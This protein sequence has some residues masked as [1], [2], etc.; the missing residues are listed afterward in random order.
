M[1]FKPV[2]S[3]VK[4]PQL[5]EEMLSFWQE[6][7]V[8]E[9][10]LGQRQGNE[11][12]VFYDGPPFATGLPHYGHLLAGTI[13]DVI[14]RFQ[15]M[16][17]K[18]V[19]R[20]F[21]WDCHGL[22]IESLIQ[23]ELKLSGVSEIQEFGIDKFNEACRDSVLTYTNEW[24]QTVGR[25]GR[26]VDFKNGYK[27][28]D[29]D[30]MESVWWV[31][32]RC[33]DLGLIYQGYR[34]QPYSPALATPLS[35]FETNQ[36]YKDRQDPSLT[37]LFPFHNEEKT[38][39]IVWTTTPWTLPSNMAVAVGADIDYV[40]V[41]HEDWKLWVAAARKDAYFGEE[42]AVIATAKGS[43]LA[44]T[45]YIS[46]FDYI[47]ERK[48]KLYQIQLADF[49]ST[50]DGTGA[51]HIAPSFGEDDFI[52]GQALGLPLFDP[53]DT[54]GKFTNLVPEWQ[55]QGAK[56][57]DKSIIQHLKQKGRIFKHETFVHSYPHCY[58][59]GV[60]L[61]YR[62]LKTWFLS[63]DK[64]LTNEDGETKLLKQWM[65]DN[66][67]QI[68]WVPD[69]IKDGRFGKWLDNARDW[70]LSRNRFWGTP[71]PVWIAEDGDMLCVGSCEE[72]E[73]LSNQ[74][75][76]DL[77]KHIV[78]TRII[79]TND[80]VNYSENGKEY[81]RTSEVFDCW[82]ES[83]SMPFAQKHYP[84]DNEDWLKEHFPADFIAE[85]LDQTRGWFYTLTILASALFQKPAFKNVIVNGLILGDDGEKM[86][87]SK[88]N[89]PPIEGVL[90]SYGADAMR[91]CLLSSP[92]VRGEFMAFT[93]QSVKETMRNVLI[94]FWNSYS[95]F[96]TYANVDNW[97]PKD[98]VQTLPTQLD[99]PLDQW[100]ISRLE[101]MVADVAQAIEAYEL[102]PAATRFVEFIEQL[103]NWYIRRS[104]RRFW[105][106]Q[107]DT[108]KDQAY[109]T[110]YHVLV[111]FTKVAAPFIPFLTDSVYRNLRT[112]S[113]PESVHLC[114]FPTAADDAVNID[115]DR[116]MDK[117]MI[118]VSLGRYLRS[119][120]SMRVRQ[121]LAEVILVSIDETTRQDLDAMQDVISEELNVKEVIIR[122]NE[123][124]LVH[125]SAKP[126]FPKLG[127]KLGPKMKL[128]AQ[129][130]GG[131]SA[132]Q[133]QQLQEGN[134]QTIEL[135]GEP[136]ELN[137]EDIEIR[138]AEK[139]GLAVAN[140]GDVTVALD[141]N[142][143]EE[144]KQEGSARELVHE[145]QDKRKQLDFE[146]SDR[147]EIIFD[148]NLEL[149]SA[150]EKF[151]DYI[152]NETLANELKFETL[153]DEYNVDNSTLSG[154]L[155]IKLTKIS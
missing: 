139:D 124:E 102:Q 118:A 86:S 149:K 150:I 143:S 131:L 45:K 69:H 98:Q 55:G 129:A 152:A 112:T 51:V 78:D 85:G 95:F 123:S 40:Q 154:V 13:K 61:L 151:S 15:T 63:L 137:A 56:D 74:P 20:V 36:G 135:D 22:P 134:A 71:I 101:G 34:I 72:L 93:E 116:K 30:F 23:N 9:K 38:A 2:S 57:A 42:A 52:L 105:K 70:N 103:T 50:E 125:L 62:A 60:P 29:T 88:K 114:D 32:K 104:R 82:F 132:D 147:I 27:T 153:A 66:N 119:Q 43:D 19:E 99:N 37:V 109:A 24:E 28:M 84:F 53:L 46:L 11:E 12:F 81:I 113:M 67:Q 140:E 65:I 126:N 25:M 39:M 92:V 79:R 68:R 75:I 76:D 59:T 4:F 77:H 16:R 17:G 107:N 6:Q 115:L 100:V 44:G 35:N 142:L 127:P 58:R 94:P 108:D 111:T 141:L 130:I 117:A 148:T 5:E 90:D 128:A 54:E 18:Y 33:W 122:E 21:G 91:L 10:S 121:P 145:I 3:Q 47:E 49:V 8:F 41:A 89:Y 155:K 97:Q 87:K 31:F 110:L 96:V 133:I 106:S 26:W 7:G 138:R 73:K 120:A 1:N 146:V 48:D 136:F 144:L 64:E 83:G 14:P 80:K